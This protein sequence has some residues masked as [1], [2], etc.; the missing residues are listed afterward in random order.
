MNLNKML[1][2]PAVAAI[3]C[4]A[5][6]SV[7]V[8]N[9]VGF[10]GKGDVQTA[11]GWNNPQLQSN[12]GGV[13]F[14]YNSKDTYDVECEWTTTTGGPNPKIIL[15]DIIVPKHTSIKATVAYD[16]RTMKQITGFNLN[17]YGQTV[18]VGTVPV[19]G[20]TCPG[21]SQLAVITAVQL[22]SSTGGLYVN[23]GNTSVPL[24]NTP[25]V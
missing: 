13:T 8:F 14:T 9:G 6:A 2:G 22:T 4:A 10:V 20:G 16:A 19:V 7:S 25:T 18:T 23:F 15:H 5:L 11:F 12:A 17:G 21:G 1:A 3:A 24:P